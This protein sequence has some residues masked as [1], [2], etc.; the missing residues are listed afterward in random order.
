MSTTFFEKGKNLA[1][2]AASITPTGVSDVIVISQASEVEVIS[3]LNQ[4]LL[5]T[6]PVTQKAP[7]AKM[8]TKEAVGVKTARLLP[9]A[10]K[11]KELMTALASK[12]PDAFVFNAITKAQKQKLPSVIQAEIE[13]EGI[14]SGSLVVITVDDFENPANSRD[15][16]S[17]L[18]GKEN[19]ELLVSKNA[20]PP[21]I[22]GAK[23]SVDG[24]RIGKKVVTK[25]KKESIRVMTPAP[26]LDTVGDQKTLVFLIET[27]DSGT[28]PFTREE[29]NILVFNGQFQKFMKEQSY[30]RVSFSGDVTDW[31]KL[32]KDSHN[33][34]CSAVNL[35]N[36]EEVKNY[37]IDKGIDLSHYSRIIYL[38]AGGSGG[39]S[40]IGK[41][42]LL[43]NGSS[44]NFSMTWV[45]LFTYGASFIGGDFKDTDFVLS[46]EIGHALGLQHANGWDCRV[47]NDPTSCINVE[48]ANLFD[49]MGSG[50]LSLHFNASYKEALGW[51]NPVDEIV[52]QKKGNYE[53]TLNPLESFLGK[54]VLKIKN[55][56]IKSENNIP[57]FIEFRQPIGFDG[58]LNDVKFNFVRNGLLV[59]K[60]FS[61]TN[62]VVQS[63]LID[64]SNTDL[65]WSD[66]IISSVV[67]GK[68]AD[69]DKA[70]FSDKGLGITVGPIISVIPGKGTKPAQIKFN[71]S[72]V[73]P[74][75]VRQDSK[76]VITGVPQKMERGMYGAVAVELVNNSSPSCGQK[77][78][79]SVVSHPFITVF[80]EK[81]EPKISTV[82]VPSEQRNSF[83]INFTVLDS[84]PQNESIGWFT[85]QIKDEAGRKTTQKISIPIVQKPAIIES[86]SP[87]S[88][89]S[90]EQVTITGFGFSTKTNGNDIYISGGGFNTQIKGVLSSDGTK[91][92]FVFPHT[93]IDKSGQEVSTPYG[94]YLIQISADTVYSNSVLFNIP[95]QYG[96]NI[97][98][99]VNYIFGSRD[100]LTLAVGQ[101]ATDGVFQTALVSVSANSSGQT[102]ANFNI[103][104]KG[105]PSG[106]Y[107]LS[108]GA[109]SGMFSNPL[110]L[111]G[112]AFITVT[113]I[114]LR[115]KTATILI[116]EG[117]GKG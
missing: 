112:V 68:S 116:S 102:V 30:N 2:V 47:T 3:L 31:I 50:S 67:F 61:S 44:F 49:T 39:C 75:C 58:T 24:Y 22:S 99:M 10:K 100:G 38:V 74:V 101:T 23:V 46:H 45:G 51:I 34:A 93:I 110:Y 20:I 104:S 81:D 4:E 64:V 95:E 19:L 109:I 70:V 105:Y 82:I 115:N 78:Q 114:D 12:D 14:T 87:V 28:R 79:M 98:L 18:S 52:I 66:D 77:F 60:L 76:I 48:Y 56:D 91:L 90:G 33:S 7:S 41:S 96:G 5:G 55:P 111:S 53:V 117:S 54:R 26:N 35:L 73:K 25:A 106:V 69:L 97:P 9:L 113:S 59:N 83:Y 8:V 37:I 21:S 27:N 72:V 13:E 32:N 84:F 11:R 107:S 63:R 88:S 103:N 94:D 86:I 29:A 15:Q 65:Q 62:G 16:Y 92:S 36:D 89:F 71:V 85:V 42:Y 17:L 6:Y 80:R 57:V 43:F 1:L 40:M 108:E